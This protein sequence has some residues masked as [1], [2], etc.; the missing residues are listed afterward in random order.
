[1]TSRGQGATVIVPTLNRGP[2]L[3]DTLRD[4]VAQDYR[5]LEI[6]VVD[7][8]SE[9]SL[10]VEHYA[11]RFPELISYR[12]VPF[13]GLPLARNYGW[14]NAKYEALV[15]VD[16]DIR[17][18]PSLVREHMR[19]LSQAKVGMVAG[20]IDERIPAPRHSAKPG[21]FCFWTATP[22]RGFD[23]RGEHFVTHVPGGN[24]STWRSVLA[25][26]GGADEALAVGAALYEET[27][28]SLRVIGCGFQIRFNGNARLMHLAARQGGCRVPDIVGYVGSL[29]HNRVILISRYLKWFHLPTAYMRL[30]LLITS[31]A[32]HYRNIRV[33]DAALRGIIAG[34]R[35]AK[36]PR[37]CSDYGAA[38]HV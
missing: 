21:K 7:Q 13:R 25:L 18:G 32:A 19:S 22:S 4:I 36:Q 6:L 8:S 17:C 1:M 23:H 15:F 26:A 34:R 12:R 28:L 38:V 37:L 30:V 10:E 5:P 9:P 11:D 24:F 16:D 14:Q 35:H 29:A 3:L 20:G 31:Y 2:Y 33:V 27:D